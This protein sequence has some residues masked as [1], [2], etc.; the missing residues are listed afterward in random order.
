MHS[1]R[2][3]LGSAVSDFSAMRTFLGSCA[4]GRASTC[5]PSPRQG[6][7]ASHRLIASSETYSQQ[8][9]GIGGATTVKRPRTRELARRAFVG[10]STGLGDTMRQFVGE[11]GRGVD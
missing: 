6:S 11:G 10:E 4:R 7:R 9:Q 3:K 1:A 5:K 8:P 2:M